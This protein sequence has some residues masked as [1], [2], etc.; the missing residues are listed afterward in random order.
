MTV[1]GERPRVKQKLFIKTYGCQMNVYDSNRMV[2]ILAPLGYELTEEQDQ[3]DMVIFN[4]CHIREKAAE[5]LYSDL[6]RAK[7]LKEA[8]NALGKDQLIAVAG[9]TAQAE[10]A[11]VIRRA[12]YVDMVVGPQ[13]YHEFPEMLA[14]AQRQRDMSQNNAQAGLGIIKVEFPD[15]PKFDHLPEVTAHEGYSAFVAIQEGCDKFC[16][17][18]VVP[19]TR[20]AEYSRPTSDVI[21]EVKRLVSL[22]VKEVTLLGQNVN[23]YHGKA[24]NGDQEWSMGRLIYELA[25]IDGLHQMRYM[26]SHP[27]DVNDELIA[28]H[29]DVQKLSPFLHL[30]VQSGSDRILKAM[31]RKHTVAFYMEIIEKFRA[32]RPDIA[33]S[34][35]FIVG[36]P[37]E[38]DRDFEDT[39]KLVQE[40]GY[41][42]AYSFKY[43]KRPGTP[44]WALE[45]QV[46]ENVKTERLAR[47]QALL[48]EQQK[49]FNEQ[50]VGQVM[51]VLM[52]KAGRRTGQLVAR[53][54]YMQSVYVNAPD[55]LLGQIIDVRITSS[56]NNSLTGEVVTGD[57]ISIGCM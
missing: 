7:P 45:N 5:K 17:F 4:T 10:G 26:T 54:P 43:S 56:G 25:E 2:D 12:P 52:E 38:E 46:D 36:Y 49:D 30:P 9:C 23:A 14:R 33:F 32:A 11:E 21:K 47:L 39:L 55:R 8:R 41:S 29:R 28:A 53:S 18:C 57:D 1:Y 34:S 42:Q 51:S 13:S 40:V 37:G 31:N 44:A 15:E 19:Y 16:N 20:G 24:P 48:N 6:G 22:G 35:D 27:R 50:S 3:A